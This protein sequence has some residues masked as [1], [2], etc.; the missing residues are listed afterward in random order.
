MH[1]NLKAAWC[2]DSSALFLAKFV[3]RMHTNCYFWASNSDNDTGFDDSDFYIM[4]IFR[5]SVGI[6]EHF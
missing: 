4:Q 3:Q 5:Q 2:H 1:C 6:N